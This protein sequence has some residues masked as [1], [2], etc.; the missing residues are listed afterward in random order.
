MYCTAYCAVQVEYTCMLNLDTAQLCHCVS[1]TV[2]CL[3]TGSKSTVCAVRCSP[4]R[5]NND[6][7]NRGSISSVTCNWWS[8]KC[9]KSFTV[10]IFMSSG[11][12]IRR[13]GFI[14]WNI[15]PYLCPFSL[16]YMS[17]RKSGNDR[18]CNSTGAMFPKNG[19]GFSEGTFCFEKWSWVHV[20][21]MYVTRSVRPVTRAHV[22]RDSSI[23]RS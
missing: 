20:P 8:K 4:F 12:R 17:E 14:K 5:L 21:N 9:S 16:L 10:T 19:M 15:P 2:L 22:D 23:L 6:F 1:E 11:S 7:P 18:V 13:T 3:L